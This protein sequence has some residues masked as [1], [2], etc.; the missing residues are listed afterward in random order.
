MEISQQKFS[1]YLCPILRAS[2]LGHN[3]QQVLAE[4]E[5]KAQ[6]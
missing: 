2:F 1:L 3:F 4:A 5:H 6:T